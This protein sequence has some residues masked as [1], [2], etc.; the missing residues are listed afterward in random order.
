M[1]YEAG[2]ADVLPGIS[3]VFGHRTIRSIAATPPRGNGQNRLQ[4]GDRFSD[5]FW[6]PG[7]C[8][9]DGPTVVHGILTIPLFRQDHCAAGEPAQP[10]GDFIAGPENILAVS[11][12][13]SCLDCTAAQYSPLVLYGPHGSG[14]SH[15]ARGLADWWQR[16]FPQAR[17]GC[18]AA[19]EFAQDYARSLSDD[20]LEAWRGQIYRSQLLVVEDLGQLSGKHGAQKELRGVLDVLAETQ[21][22]VIVTARTLPTH[23]RTLLPSLRSR[24]SAG[25]AVPLALPARSTR[26]GVLDRLA[27]TGGLSLSERAL[28]SLAD[29][30]PL[31]VPAL[32]ASALELDARARVE[33]Q[34]V[35]VERARQFVALRRGATMPGLRDIACVTAKYFGLKLSDLKSPLRQRPLVAARAVAMYLSRQLTDSSLE[36]IGAFFGG[37]D[38]TTV[39]HGCRRTEKLLRR[40]RATRQAVS[41]LQRLLAVS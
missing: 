29:G 20:R 38:H 19:S 13:R 30:L 22:M 1:R 33:G 37:R 25:L 23:S 36:R 24:L 34:A 16:H 31:S 6:P 26:R 14:K 9:L 12:I 10:L 40:D 2:P 17:V 35:D 32:I 15:L 18:L 21:A 41:E 7:S 4:F 5:I 39:L 8:R 3:A 27:A 28:H 11:A